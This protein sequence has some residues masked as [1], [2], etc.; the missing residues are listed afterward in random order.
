MGQEAFQFTCLLFSLS[1]TPWVFTKT[2]RPVAAKLRELGIQ[3]VIYLDDILVIASSP[4]QLEDHASTL[5]YTLENLGFIVHPEKSMTQPTQRM[6]FL[7]MIV[8]MV[9][10]ELQVPGQKIKSVRTEARK[11]LDSQQTPTREVTRLIGKMTSM[12]QAIP[13]A[14]CFT[15]HSRGMC[16]GP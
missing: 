8:D 16:F 13:P 3:L 4:T 5:V 6:E 15:G 7:G 2:L 14:H 12:A 1:S 9:S 11:L 10:M